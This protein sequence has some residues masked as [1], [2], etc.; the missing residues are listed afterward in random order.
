MRFGDSPVVIA[1]VYRTKAVTF[2]ISQ[3]EKNDGFQD[4]IIP[5]HGLG[6]WEAT[7]VFEITYYVWQTLKFLEYFYEMGLIPFALRMREVRLQL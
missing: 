3:L 2:G 5:N 6:Q 7:D 4:S 1:G